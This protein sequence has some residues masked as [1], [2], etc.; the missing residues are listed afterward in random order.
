VAYFSGDFAR[1]VFSIYLFTLGAVLFFQALLEFF[2][3]EKMYGL[4]RS[5][6][7]CRWYPL[8]GI[9]LSAGALPL[10]FFRDTAAGKA[11]MAAGIV[12]VL[13]GPFIFFY[14]EKVRE[15]F[16]ETEE[17]IGANR[18]KLMYLDAVVRAALAILMIFVTVRY[19]HV[20]DKLPLSW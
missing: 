20:I 8:H 10:T 19:E 14:T 18:K 2:F 5:W 9:I 11:M 16:K 17:E 12:V 4:Q 6:I 1:S 7:F 15:I 13:T 3:P